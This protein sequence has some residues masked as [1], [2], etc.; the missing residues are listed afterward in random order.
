[1]T[2]LGDNTKQAVD[3]KDEIYCI[4]H[5][6]VCDTVVHKGVMVKLKTDGTVTPTTAITDNPIGKIDA[7]N[8]AEGANTPVTVATKFLAIIRGTADG[9]IAIGDQV[10]GSGVDNTNEQGKFKTTVASGANVAG[11]ALSAGA[12][13]ETVTIGIYRT[14]AV[15]A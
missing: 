4:A 14:P 1:M 11:V 12:D 2:T 10:Y 3:W 7:G 13:T 15:I 5:K 8:K 9:A 6:F